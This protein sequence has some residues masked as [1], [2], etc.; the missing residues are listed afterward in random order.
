MKLHVIIPVYNVEKYL[1]QCVESVLSQPLQ[2]LDIVLVD[3]GSP[4]NSGVICD[5][6]AARDSRISVIHQ[7]NAGVSAARNAGIESVLETAGDADYIAFLD[8]DDI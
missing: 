4:D 6:L 1:R 7:T 5:E 8:A 2:D 3:D